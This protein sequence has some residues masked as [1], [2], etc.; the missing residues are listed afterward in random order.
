[1]SYI[2]LA[3]S[4]S[5]FLNTIQLKYKLGSSATYERSN[6]YLGTKRII[7]YFDKALEPKYGLS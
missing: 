5:N 3:Q 7:D 1:M 4:Q 2:P 6:D